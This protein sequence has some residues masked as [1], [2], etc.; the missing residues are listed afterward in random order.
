MNEEGLLG[1]WPLAG[2]TSDHSPA[3]H[4]T[5]AVEVE[6]GAEG[7]GGRPGTAACF[8][9]ARSALEVHDRPGLRFGTGDFSVALWVRDD[10]ENGDVIGDLVSKFDPVARRGFQLSAVSNFGVTSTA[11][12]NRRQLSFGIDDGRIDPEWTDCGRPGLSLIH[13]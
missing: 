11:Q 12:S 10:P 9:G 2:D 13:I 5:N 8:N 7:P 1:R 3:K 4:P 6:L